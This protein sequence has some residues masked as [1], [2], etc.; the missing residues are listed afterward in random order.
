MNQSVIIS[1][2][3]TVL[4]TSGS[5]ADL[6][7][8]GNLV[9]EGDTS[10]QHVTFNAGIGTLTDLSVT[11]G[12]AADHGTIA[13]NFTVGGNLT[14]QDVFAIHNVNVHNDLEVNG[15]AALT[16][17]AGYL[18]TDPISFSNVGLSDIGALT[19]TGIVTAGGGLGVGSISGTVNP[20]NFN[21]FSVGFIDHLQINTLSATGGGTLTISGRVTMTGSSSQ[22]V[23]APGFAGNSSPVVITPLANYLGTMYVTTGTNGQFTIV[24]P[25]GFIGDVAYMYTV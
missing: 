19:T 17:V 11:G 22:L 12:V 10:L 1:G 7:L 8:T 24:A 14:G 25:G 16:R 20:I 4:T 23:I 13:A 5:I 2:S 9:V 18:G 3:V 15:T 6:T 21:G